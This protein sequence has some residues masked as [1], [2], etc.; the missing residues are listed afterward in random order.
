[1]ENYKMKSNRNAQI[2]DE[3]ISKLDIEDSTKTQLFI[4]LNTAHCLRSI[5]EELIQLNSILRHKSGIDQ[6]DGWDSSKNQKDTDDIPETVTNDL[7]DLRNDLDDLSQQLDDLRGDVEYKSNE[8]HD[9]DSYLTGI[10]LEDLEDKIY[11]SF[12]EEISNI[13]KDF[14]EPKNVTIKWRDKAD[15]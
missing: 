3:E 5:K 14:S 4:Q 10:D 13:K 1:M 9:H 2:I 12:R 11:E 8:D 7:G 15:E 6:P